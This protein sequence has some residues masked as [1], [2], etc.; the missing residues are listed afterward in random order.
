MEVFFVILSFLVF[1][2][3]FGELAERLGMP[4]LV[5]ELLSG[6]LL[7]VLAAALAGVVPV[8]GGLRDSES[9]VLI[10]DFSMFFLMLLAGVEMEPRDMAKRSGRAFAVAFG[11]M[12]LPLGFGFALGLWVLPESPLRIAQALFLGTALSVTAVPVTVRIFMDLDRLDTEV[13][14]TVVSAALFDDILSLFILSLLIGMMNGEPQNA[15][16]IGFLLIKIGI[17]F[18]ITIP[19]GWFVF[20]RVGRYFKHFLVREIDLSMLLIAAFAY[21]VI[22]E[23]LGLH[24]IVGAFLAGVFFQR[25]VVDPEVYERVEGQLSGL[26]TGFLA[27]IFFA[28]VGL[29]LDGS[30]LLAVPL[31][32]VSLVVIAMLSKIVGAGLAA[33]W[34]GMSALDSSIVGVGMSGRGAVELIIANLALQAGLFSQPDPPPPILANMFSAVVIMAV[35]TTVAA[36]I[37]L[38]WGLRRESR[39]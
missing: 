24:Y 18:A 35:V 36:P 31:F 5:G 21:A 29:H 38:R 2:R 7:G 4:S 25:P 33:R 20:P 11:G 17:F 19:I 16:S 37:L 8:L 39:T 28:S 23:L 32:V 9:L 13:G 34:T 26:T 12:A 15:E 6:V 30:A 10:T 22:A 1:T 27:P 3:L 14:R